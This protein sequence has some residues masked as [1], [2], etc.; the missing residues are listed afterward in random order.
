MSD[1]EVREIWSG[2]ESGRHYYQ[3]SPGGAVEGSADDE[4]VVVVDANEARCYRCDVKADL[5]FKC[6]H[7]HTVRKTLDV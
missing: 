3:V 2:K 7:I 1:R 5:T 4:A 6:I